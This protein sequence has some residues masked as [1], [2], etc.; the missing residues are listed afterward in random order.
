MSIDIFPDELPVIGGGVIGLSIGWQ[1]RRIGIP[2]AIYDCGHPQASRVAAGMI[3]PHA[4]AALV[5]VRL[6]EKGRESLALFPRFLSELA[7]DSGMEV[8]LEQ[9][10]TLLVGFD[11]DDAQ[12]LERIN[13]RGKVA[14]RRLSGGEARE[15]EPLLSPRVTRAILVEDDASIDPKVFMKSLKKAYLAIG[16]KIKEEHVEEAPVN[17]IVAGGVWSARFGAEVRPLKG[18][19]ATF[20]SPFPLRYMIRSPRVYLTPNG[21]AIRV[22]ATSE[23]ASFNTD[24]TGEALRNLLQDGWEVLPA[25]DS[26]P[27][28]S[29]EAGLRP[30][31]DSHQPLIEQRGGLFFATGHGRS[32]FLLAPYTAY[33]IK[34]MVCRYYSTAKNM[35]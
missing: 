9:K 18:Q 34:E 4:E 24:T 16:G 25:L 13:K 7:N 12:W 3:A 23:E 8:S 14:M 19:I 15:L 31:T 29:F 27:V 6:L 33:K 1:L 20:E 26:M 28:V 5:N 32:G 17:G 2:A 21:S 10:G 30:T 11:R 22:G 35:K